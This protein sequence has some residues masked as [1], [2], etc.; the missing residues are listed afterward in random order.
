MEIYMKDV[1]IIG[2]GILG[3]SLAHWLTRLYEGDICVLEKED[4]IASH[5]SGRNTGV[6]HRPFYLDPEKNK[7]FTKSASLMYDI[8][9]KYTLENNLPWLEVGTLEIAIKEEQ[10]NH[11]EKYLEWGEL[12]GIDKKDLTLLSRREVKNLEPNVECVAALR[13][14][15][16]TAVDYSKLTEQLKIDAESN[17][18]KFIL[19]SH[20]EH[21]KEDDECVS[22]HVKNISKPIQC[23]LMINCAGGNSVDIAHML[24][25]GKEYTD[26][27]FRGEYW[28][29]DQ[30][31]DSIVNTNIYSVPRHPSFPF[32]D[33]HWIIRVDGRRQ[34]GPNAVPVAGPNVYKGMAIDGN[35][36]ISKII[37]I[38]QSGT[39]KLI[40][41]PEFLSLFWNEWMSSLSK[42]VMIK[43]AQQFIPKL[44][45][46]YFTRK[47]TAGIRSPVLNNTGKFVSDTIELDGP[48]TYHILNYNSPGATGAPAYAAYIINRL[49]EA[50]MLNLSRKNKQPGIWNFEQIVSHFN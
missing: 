20:V 12:N 28:I 8:W 7:I 49:E 6:L 3:T 13:C 11:L 1:V 46:G 29:A 45:A 19:N 10:Y 36:L 50:K 17:G 38:L 31:Y 35:E 37:E 39:R 34:I 44:K 43:R 22:I 25:I 15:S 26:L 21:V 5:A 30:P 4:R 27:H 16:D 32:L 47:G 42:D 40:L 9:K 33:P 24:N 18:A 41:N 48:H 2:G 23:K 14:K